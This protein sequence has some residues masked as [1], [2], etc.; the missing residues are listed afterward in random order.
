MPRSK[1]NLFFPQRNTQVWLCVVSTNAYSSPHR[2]AVVSGRIRKGQRVFEAKRSQKLDRLWIGFRPKPRAAT[3]STSGTS[4]IQLQWVPTSTVDWMPILRKAED[5]ATDARHVFDL[6]RRLSI[7]VVGGDETS[8][9]RTRA[10]TRSRTRTAS[11]PVC[12]DHFEEVMT[13]PAASDEVATPPLHAQEVDAIVKVGAYTARSICHELSAMVKAIV[14]QAQDIVISQSH[15]PHH[16]NAHASAKASTQRSHTIRNNHDDWNDTNAHLNTIDS[17]NA[18]RRAVSVG[19]LWAHMD[20]INAMHHCCPRE[21]AAAFSEY[22]TAGCDSGAPLALSVADLN[23]WVTHYF[24]ADAHLASCIAPLQEFLKHELEARRRHAP[25][26]YGCCSVLAVLE[27]MSATGQTL[28]HQRFFWKSFSQSSKHA[29]GNSRG[30]TGRTG[31]SGHPLKKW[32]GAAATAISSLL[33]GN[34]QARTIGVDDAVSVEAARSLHTLT[35]L[36]HKIYSLPQFRQHRIWH[37]RT[38]LHMV[39]MSSRSLRLLPHLTQLVG[40]EKA[41][42]ELWESSQTPTTSPATSR[43]TSPNVSRK[44][45][46]NDRAF[47]TPPG[48]PRSRADCTTSSP[49]SAKVSKTVLSFMDGKQ[50]TKVGPILKVYVEELDSY[51]SALSLQM[52]QCKYLESVLCRQNVYFKQ[53]LGRILAGFDGLNELV[54]RVEQRFAVH[55]SLL[56]LTKAALQLAAEC[57]RRRHVVIDTLMR[58]LD[59][60]GI[61]V[62]PQRQRPRTHK[63]RDMLLLQALQ[64]CS[65][66]QYVLAQDSVVMDAIKRWDDI[67]TQLVTVDGHIDVCIAA[68]QQHVSTTISAFRRQVYEASHKAAEGMIL[69]EAGVHAVTAGAGA[70]STSTAVRT[71]GPWAD[72]VL[73]PSSVY[74]SNVCS[75]SF[76]SCGA[77][78]N[79]IL[80]PEVCMR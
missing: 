10:R 11:G 68:A 39:H 65:K 47:V 48:S 21:S 66:P 28:L 55:T 57:L 75:S 40:G 49:Q 76:L 20:I 60:D 17:A 50:R 34:K 5:Y 23:E 7:A 2:D 74:L 24:R 4:N 30:D 72:H 1:L 54:E 16:A 38:V 59:D 14:V 78:A 22:V 67:Q 73:Q 79:N 61:L 27:N 43:C 44:S 36:I 42:K 9:A 37:A 19:T 41:F 29:V 69:R 33:R 45:V 51:V 80:L 18:S 56:Q 70:S 15:V 32:L 12:L 13:K 53:V 63:Q 3:G 62:A 25:T 58:S 77:L 26:Q 64:Y 8:R 46:R 31:V 71:T 6:D 52:R 35:K